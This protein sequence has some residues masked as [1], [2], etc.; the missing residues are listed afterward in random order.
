M[1][2]CIH[3]YLRQLKRGTLYLVTSQTEWTQTASKQVY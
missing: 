1:A 2:I 3:T